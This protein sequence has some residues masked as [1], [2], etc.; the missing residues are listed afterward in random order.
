MSGTDL[1]DPAI[2]Q[3][4]LAPEGALHGA[5]VRP[6]KMRWD[7]QRYAG[8]SLLEI[9]IAAGSA[10]PGVLQVVRLS[11][12]V[13]V[14]AMSAVQARQAADG[15]RLR[16]Q[17]PPT[18]EGA[19]GRRTPRTIDI[20]APAYTWHLN[21][22]ATDSRAAVTAW[23]SSSHA[24]VWL[25]CPPSY[26]E[27]LRAEL[28]AL[29]AVAPA[30]ITLVETGFPSASHP[31]NIFDAAGDAALLS[32]AAGRPVRVPVQN[33]AQSDELS[34][35]RVVTGA[36]AVRG[37][38]DAGLTGAFG[39]DAAA[40]ADVSGVAA[41]DG[42]AAAGA[43][44]N[45]GAS[46]TSA[47]SSNGDANV[48]AATGA[49]AGAGQHE[50][51][52]GNR[53]TGTAS[54]S[55]AWAADMP[56]ALRP[57]MARLLSQPLHAD[58]VAWP[59]LM[60]VAVH[61]DT[62][63][64]SG[65]PLTHASL[66]EF[67]ALQVFAQET[68]ID[69][70]A[71]RLDADPVAY[72][73]SQLPSGP[74]RTLT[75]RV[76]EQA[77]WTALGAPD[78]TFRFAPD[79]KRAANGFANPSALAL[80]T[81]GERDMP[82]LR[83]RGF[84]AAHVRDAAHTGE[85]TETWSAWVVEVEVEPQSGRVDV[86][87]LV[88]G[89]DTQSLHAAQPASVREQD[90]LL[91]DAA[92]RLLRAPTAFDDWEATSGNAASVQAVDRGP[93]S[94]MQTAGDTSVSARIDSG[95]LALDGVMTLPAAA[96]IG[97]AIFDATGVRLRAAPFDT[98]ALRD[99]LAGEASSAKAPD[100]RQWLRR[101]GVWL[102]TGASAVAGV[103]T[104]AWPTKPAIAPTAGPDVSLYSDAA[105]ERGRLVAVAGD[106]VVCH[107]APDGKPNA[108]GL[109]L[110]TPFGVIYTTNITPD[111]ETGI[112]QWS[113]RAFERAMR[114][115]VHRDGRQ[116]YPA[117]PYTAFAKMSEADMQALYA[118]MMVQPPV[119]NEAP[120][121][122]LAFPFNMRPLLAGWNVLFHDTGVY[123]P[124]PTQSL[125]W[126]RGAYLVQGAGHCAACHS[127]RN[128]LGAEKTGIQHYLAGGEAEGWKAPPLNR[129][130]SGRSPWTEDSLVQYLRTGYSVNHGV[131]AGPMAPVI[132]GLAQLSESDVRAMA[133]YLLNL[134]GS[135]AP[136]AAHESG[137]VSPSAS[138]VGGTAAKPAHV[139]AGRVRGERIYQ[140]ACA[141][142]HEASSGPTLFGV[143]PS[144]ATN[145]NLYTDAPD[146]L[147]QVILHG[148][149]KPAN[150]DLGY[151]PGFKD[152]LDDDQIQ[153]L[154]RY[155]R[156]R[157]APQEPE[158][159]DSRE[160]IGRIRDQTH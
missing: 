132:Q 135:A 113:Y 13:G 56:W 88:V 93:S 49:S 114:E 94:A 30:R 117:F 98:G 12:F 31:L 16:W 81:R 112:G 84:A 66:G 36:A 27:I 100:A 141:V 89:H 15:L 25:A 28:G 47:A 9:D 86:T 3:N 133:T 147:V 69:E 99:R 120:K 70:Q 96:A 46:D 65:A 58:P 160:L 60:D 2:S 85:G 128:A 68:W 45:G 158:W 101:A 92:R 123:Q 138:A 116:L 11:E 57:S 90:P 76:A 1:T 102:A 21:P 103:V 26:Q 149:Q 83:G 29:L 14:V 7:G 78:E 71:A 5:V 142:C 42:V 105:I 34:L 107:T 50:T 48:A 55:T 33:T 80:N 106:C 62:A 97:N 119:R 155:L 4:P 23:C 61:P 44:L 38:S 143:K 150:E 148:I 146:N 20:D 110:D 51:A 109:A 127:P 10:Q 104:M 115:G 159:T 40:D 139:F 17:S 131:A 151:M 6:P 18:R 63:S 41:T 64:E 134:P 129:L 74:A 82:V 108:G 157:F 111:N 118:Y 8:A 77:N 52:S 67:E 35:R 39:A 24:T 137:T 125:A 43:T 126:N 87:R 75:Q 95:Q 54:P 152:S 59:R 124:D 37:A 22:H 154:L 53:G 136:A 140:N 122:E 72:R 145:T 79:D 153:D 156:A 121:T 91:L 144:L 73:L 32:R 130:G 19:G